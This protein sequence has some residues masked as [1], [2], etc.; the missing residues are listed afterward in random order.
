MELYAKRLLNPFQ[1]V[2]QVVAEGQVRALSFDGRVWELQFQC[3]LHRLK[4]ALAHSLPR[5]R[6][7]RIG[8]W[9]VGCGFRP[10]PLDPA[11]DRCE[12]E[13]S[14]PAVVAALGTARI[15]LPQDDHYEYWL[16]DPADQQPLALL[17]SGRLPEE[18]A[19]QTCRPCWHPP[20]A[21]QLP[22][23]STAEE[24][25]RG[26]PPV[27]YRIEHLVKQRAGQNPQARWF[28]R[29]SQGNGHEILPAGQTASR[30]TTGQFPELL[31]REDWQNPQA[32][33]LCTRYLQRL[34]PQLLVLQGLSHAGRERLEQMASQ[35]VIEL[36]NHFHLYPA[37]A[38]PQ[39]MTA[40]RVEA[41]LRKSLSNN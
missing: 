27:N 4:P 30:L 18:M 31:L 16:L 40:W 15:P 24:T 5:Y 34:A 35:Q 41:R 1:G 22:I 19:G 12:V 23:D 10:Y 29:D 8:R 33:D 17:A 25:R 11:I 2:L 36:D 38:D 7:A 32:Q 26:L 20:N 14:Y 28:V 37:V 3:D 39:R 9:E 6:Y 13:Q 21:A